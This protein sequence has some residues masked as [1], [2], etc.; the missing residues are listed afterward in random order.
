M[1]ATTL[2]LSGAIQAVVGF[3]VWFSIRRPIDLLSDDNKAMRTEITQLKD[4][5]MASLERAQTALEHKI[6]DV[7]SVALCEKQHHEL[8]AAMGEF[9]GAVLDLAHVQTKLEGTAEF[10]SE[11]NN[12]VMG[13]I[14]DVGSVA[15]LEKRVDR[16]EDKG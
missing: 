11:V 8:T 14:S 5:R 15:S 3:G 7:V 10:V 12:R 2:I 1:D 13:L 6:K 16:L 4:Q 9:R